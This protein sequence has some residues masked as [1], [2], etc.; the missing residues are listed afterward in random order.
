[1]SLSCRTIFSGEQIHELEESFKRAHYP[2][3]VAREE[4][5]V[6]TKLDEDRIQVWFQNRRAKW[7]K[8]E[9]QWGHSSVMAEYG[10]YGA[11]VRHSIPLPKS[12][13]NAKEGFKNQSFAPWLLGKAYNAFTFTNLTYNAA[14]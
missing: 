4:L 12:V 3:V 13:I 14:K 9:N 1:M 7:R 8:Q 5:A 6:A 2:D 10:L 11:M